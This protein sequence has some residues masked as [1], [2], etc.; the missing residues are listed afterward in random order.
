V[1]LHEYGH[2][3][4]ARVSTFAPIIS[5]HD[6]CTAT[7]A[8]FGHRINTGQHAWMEGFARYFASA[9]N[10]SLPAGTL[11]M[12]SAP[13]SRLESPAC[14]AV[15]LSAGPAGSTWTITPAMI[16]DFVAGILWDLVDA[17]GD[18]G[19]A[20]EGSDLIGRQDTRIFQVF[21][22]EL[23]R[24]GRWPTVVDFYCGWMDRGLPRAA[25]DSLF[26]TRG[27]PL[28]TCPGPLADSVVFRPSTGEWFNSTTGQAVVQW[29]QPGDIPVPGFYDAD[30]VPDP[31]VFRPSTGQWFIHTRF[32]GPIVWRL[33]TNGDVPVPA[34]YDADGRTDIAI[35]T[36][37]S[38][39]WRIINSSGR[40]SRVYQWG[41]PGD[42]PV[43]ADYDLDGKAD[44]AVWRPSSGLWYLVSS[45]TGAVTVH[46]WGQPGDIPLPGDF[47]RDG[48][49]DLTVFRPSTGTWFVANL[50]NGIRRALPFGLFGDIPVPGDYDHDGQTD[51]AV[52]RPATGEH[53]I[54]ASTRGQLP[55]LQWGLPTDVPLPPGP[56]YQ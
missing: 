52:F 39:E 34:D 32:N 47:D 22:R 53:L 17:P 16:E 19:A 41:Q 23:G 2:F 7:D 9:V 33:G 3:L 46:Q 36:P 55:P 18:I 1:I 48:R 38:G 56:R 25:L 31:T 45:A 29:G 40:A 15:G 50:S 43:P 20:P 28:A 21:D 12:V 5:N 14:G 37:W 6:G 51:L 10:R 27:I 13:V 30:A 54:L 26:V 44:L 4:Q 24:L 49:I 8:V 35:W 11:N 42:I